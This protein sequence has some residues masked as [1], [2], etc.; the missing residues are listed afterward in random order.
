MEENHNLRWHVEDSVNMKAVEGL[1]DI[2]LAICFLK[3]KTPVLPKW[4]G[5]LERTY[6]LI[7]IF[8]KIFTSSHL[9]I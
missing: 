3:P 6:F 7:K 1:E 8:L 4:V 5:N 9:T 2:S